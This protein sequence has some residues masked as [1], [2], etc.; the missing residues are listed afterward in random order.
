MCIKNSVG[1]KGK[2]LKPD[3]KVIQAALNLSQNKDFKLPARLSVDGVAGDK[4]YD[5]IKLF[6]KIIGKFSTPDGRVDPGPKG[7]TLKLLKKHSQKGLTKDAFTAI[8]AH[9]TKPRINTY[10]PLF[11]TNLDKNSINTPLRKAHFLAQVGHESLSFRYTEEIASGADYQGRKDLGNTKPGD[12]IR[13][14]GR[15][16]LQLTGRKNYTAY[17]AHSKL[18]LLVKGNEKLL[19]TTPKYALDASIWFWNNKKLNKRADQ[20][21]LRSVTRRVNGGY[22][23]LL[24]RQD[25]LCRAKFFLIP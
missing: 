3:V 19:S 6:Q 5:A 20:D 14:K 17:A 1:I 4:T 21:N 15:G 24:D 9:S 16:L 11:S 7:A 25:Y 8:M 10:Y 23:G 22:N 13:F 12:G 18:K 2:N